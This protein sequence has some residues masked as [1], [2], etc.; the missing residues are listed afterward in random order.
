ML[1]GGPPMPDN[2]F[3]ATQEK[4]LVQQIT[5]IQIQIATRSPEDIQLDI[6]SW[7]NLYANTFAF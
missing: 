6:T 7:N 3:F 5:L 2:N 1:T 4:P